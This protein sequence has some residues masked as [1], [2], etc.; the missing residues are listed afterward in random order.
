MH[1]FHRGLRNTMPV[2]EVVY[3][4]ACIAHAAMG[5]TTAQAQPEMPNAV[6]E[7]TVRLN[8]DASRVE[9]VAS[10]FKDS[11]SSILLSDAA[12]L[13][14][15]A[16][17]V[18]SEIPPVYFTTPNGAQMLRWLSTVAGDHE[19]LLRFFDQSG[20]VALAE[21]ATS[22]RALERRLSIPNPDDL[23]L[24]MI[25]GIRQVDGGPPGEVRGGAGDIL[26]LGGRLN[27]LSPKAAVVDEAG[28]ASS[29][30]NLRVVAHSDTLWR[31]AS[32]PLSRGPIVSCAALVLGT[33]LEARVP[34]CTGASPTYMLSAQLGLR[35]E[36]TDSVL[37]G[38]EPQTAH[39]ENT[40]CQKGEDIVKTLNWPMPIGSRIVRTSSETLDSRGLARYEVHF[41]SDT[42]GTVSVAAHLPPAKCVA[43]AVGSSKPLY[44]TLLT[45]RVLPLVNREVT[46]SNWVTFQMGPARA[47]TSLF[48]GG[49]SVG[50]LGSPPRE[51][52]LVVQVTNQIGVPIGV[53]Q[54]PT[55][56][57]VELQED[58][59]QTLP[60]LTVS[61]H[62]LATAPGDSG[63]VC[64]TVRSRRAG[65]PF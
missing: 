8:S 15:V 21:V 56:S 45:I 44:S 9:E 37:Y 11:T 16:E 55:L 43:M 12:K 54:T 57:T 10:A 60:G 6:T 33:E 29:P 48:I 61:W 13:R 2:S 1:A 36:K 3:V 28:T 26:V 23:S 39:F 53:L 41:L 50:R 62:N 38:L 59:R 19:A 24:P 58:R 20:A 25:Y 65:N 31:L 42:L 17:Y 34:F 40:D 7:L 46:G 32:P 4:V 18:S 14:S 64:V 63:R 22:A 47:D 52:Q 35:V 51:I 27:L 5:V 30:R 49:C